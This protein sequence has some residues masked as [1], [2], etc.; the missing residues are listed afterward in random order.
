M[1]MLSLFL[2]CALAAEGYQSPPEAIEAILDAPWAPGMA[3]SDDGEWIAEL[4]R[5]TLPT[6]AEL[7]EPEVKVG[8]LEINPRNNGAAR[9]YTYVGLTL[10][11]VGPAR[12]AEV[13]PV[14]LE[15]GARIRDVAF[16]SSGRHLSFTQ[17]TDTD[18]ELWVVDVQT[19]EATKLSDNL[20]GAWGRPCSWMNGSDALVCKRVPDGRGEAPTASTVPT[21]PRIDENLGRKTPAR[22]YQNLLASPHDEALFDHY[23]TSELVQFSMDGTERVWMASGLHISMSMSPDDGWMLVQTLKRPY[24]YH[25][26]ASRFPRTIQ[27]VEGASLTPVLLSDL[28]LADDVPIAFN[29]TRKG[30]RQV[31]WRTDAPHTLYLVEALDDGDASKEAEFRDAVSLL[32]A[33]FDGEPTVLWKTR[34]RFDGIRWGTDGLAMGE[35]WWYADRRTRAVW[36]DP[37]TPGAEPREAWDR[38][39]QDR[40]SDPGS[41]MMEPG[42]HGAWVLRQDADGALWFRGDGYTPEGQFPFLDR[43]DPA[44]GETTRIW[45]AADPYLEEVVMAL[46]DDRFITRRESQDSPPNYVMRTPGRSR[47]V[48]VTDI[49]DWAPAF[50]DIEKEVIRYERSDGLPL[51]ATVY[52]P[53]GY[54]R[55]KDGP[56]PAIFW[57]YPSEFKSRDDAGQVTATTKSFDRPYGSS[58]LFMLLEGYLVVDDPNIPIVGEGDTQPNDAYVE[59]LVSG[60]EAAVEAVVGRG[61]ADRDRLVIGGHSYGAF[62]TANLLAHSDLFAAGIARS[63]AYNRSLT[64]WGFQGE[65]RSYWEALDTYIEMSPFTH[66]AKIDE[67]LLLLHGANDSNPG[68]YPV[69]SERMFEALK[70]QGATVRWVELPLEEHGYR[71]RESVGH[72]LWEMLRWAD[73]YAAGDTEAAP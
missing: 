4:T 12:R 68:T 43:H 56:L 33:P 42:P 22:T 21:G 48:A 47:A 66:A 29:S 2:T 40:Y 11:S 18:L 6:V 25:V 39:Y 51:S 70:G 27:A 20:N 38:S 8:G 36:L 49:Q 7:A 72:A 63:G 62:T 19:A 14:E 46:P 52:F 45:Q 64:P 24:S 37:S 73:T 50:A 61:Y 53:P 5:R 35:E 69:Q 57:A 41:P 28:P 65:E 15:A 13:R 30:R 54:D 26:P 1:P 59:Q 9:A 58:H 34:L 32:E 23:L 31:G 44:T 3:F 60:A 67:P 17:V 10:R 16:S 55:K 71:G